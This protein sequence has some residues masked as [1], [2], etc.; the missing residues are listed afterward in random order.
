MFHA[1]AID[2]IVPYAIAA[3]KKP[4]T[5]VSVLRIPT[6]NCPLASPAAKKIDPDVDCII[7]RGNDRDSIEK[8]GIAKSQ[9]SP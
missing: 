6:Q 3:I 8:V 5:V 9:L 1:H 2:S 4:D 7:C